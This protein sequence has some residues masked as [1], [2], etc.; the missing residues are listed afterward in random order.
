[1]TLR[2]TFAANAGFTILESLVVLAIIGVLTGIAYSHYAKYK[3]LAFDTLSR[4]DLQSLFL[5]CKLYWHD[6]G[7]DQ[8]CSMAEVT[9][10][11]YKFN[12][13]EQVVISGGGTETEFA[14]LAAHEES[15][16]TLAI[17]PSGKVS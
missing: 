9:P 10:A 6:K 11:P 3:I 12:P 2:K 1:M 5:T 16:N 13:S 7:S 15:P 17:G 8:G 14:A 4:G